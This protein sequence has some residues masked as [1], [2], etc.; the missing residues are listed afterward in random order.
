MR[1]KALFALLLIPALL[2]SGGP[3]LSRQSSFV[4]FDIKGHWAA[5]EIAACSAQMLLYGYPGGDFMPDRQLT[6]AEALAVIVRGLG[7]DLQAGSAPTAGINFPPDLWKGFKPLVAAAVNKQLISREAVAG[8]GFN[9]P[10]G[11]LEVAVWLARAL[12]L[13]GGGS[14]LKFFDLF[15]ASEADRR[16]LAGVVEAGIMTGLPGSLFGPAKPLTR[17][18]M[19]SIMVRLLDGGRIKPPVGRYLVGKLVQRDPAA[20]KITIQSAQGT[21]S[22]VLAEGCPVYRQGSETALDKINPGENVRVYLNNAGKCAFIG[23]FSG[24][25]PVPAAGPEGSG[26]GIRGQVVNKYWDYFTVRLESQAVEEIPLSGVTLL[27]GGRKAEYSEIAKGSRVELVKTGPLVTAVNILGGDR[28]VFGGVEQVAPSFIYVKDSDGHTNP[29]PLKEGTQFRDVTGLRRTLDDVVPGVLVELALDAAGEVASVT[30]REGNWELEGTVESVSLAE[31]DRSISILDNLGEVR[32]YGLKDTGLIVREGGQS[33]NPDYIKNGMYVRLHRDNLTLVDRVE[34]AGRSVVEGKV[35]GVFATGAR[36]IV[37]EV[38]D[39]GT[40]SYPLADGVTAREGG[41]L[42]SLDHESLNDKSVRLNLNSYG[43][44]TRILVTNWL[45]VEGTVTSTDFGDREIEVRGYGGRVETYRLAEEVTVRVDGGERG[46]SEVAPGL[47]VRLSLNSRNRVVRIEI[48]GAEDVEGKIIYV[49][50]AGRKRIQIQR[51]G[52]GQ[53]SYDLADNV[54]VVENGA[55]RNLYYLVGGMN[56]RLL[57]SGSDL[58]ER[59][60]VTGPSSLEGTVVYVDNTPGA[61]TIRIGRGTGTAD[62]YPLAERVVV[63]DGSVERGLNYVIEGMDVRLNLDSAG[64]VN[65]IEFTGTFTV[66]GRV[67]SVDLTGTGSVTVA[68]NSGAIDSYRVTFNVTI[69][70]GGINRRLNEIVPGMRVKLTLDRAEAV[71]RIEIS[72]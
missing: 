22:H 39:G 3:A 50:F 71:T 31:G 72:G 49:Q 45:S 62:T 54:S 53:E 27:K 9:D 23:L 8:T 70:Q 68:K 38:V 43:Q 57:V 32:T 13:E 15:D 46:L 37:I 34:I 28:K 14:G 56:V 59:I 10:A 48:T 30:I 26:T 51:D 19:A 36:K 24:A 41:T 33:R 2:L 4:F 17:A 63:R 11:R 12:N 66:E 20:Q 60:T 69:R 6:R 64:R 67:K 52:G 55:P 29:Y 1:F 42:L 40:E 58:V 25:V 18:E 7:W 61:R 47:G 65:L 44:V 5:G 35:R 16:L 21:A